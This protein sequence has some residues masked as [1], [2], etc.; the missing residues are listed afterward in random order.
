ML[1]RLDRRDAENRTFSRWIK[2]AFSHY[3]GEIDAPEIRELK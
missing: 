2:L 1:K 3:A